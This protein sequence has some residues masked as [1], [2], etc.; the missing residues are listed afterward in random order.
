MDFFDEEFRKENGD[1]K[2]VVRR[3]L[4]EQDRPLFYGLVGG[5]MFDSMP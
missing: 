1:W 2:K 5:R 4:Y 3:Y